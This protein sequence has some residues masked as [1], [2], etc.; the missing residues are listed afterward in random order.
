[1]NF[2]LVFEFLKYVVDLFK[3]K[4]LFKLYVFIF[5]GLFGVYFIYRIYF[6]FG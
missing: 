6:G 2:S 1:M 3:C 4:F 5:Y